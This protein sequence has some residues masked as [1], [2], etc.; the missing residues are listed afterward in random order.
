MKIPDEFQNLKPYDMNLYLYSFV[1]GKQQN[2][3]DVHYYYDENLL[4]FYVRVLFHVETQGAPGIVHG[5]AIASVMD[6]AM[7][8]V[9]FLNHLPAVTGSLTLNY[10]R[11]LPVETTMYITTSIEKTEGKR[12]YIVGK[13]FDGDGVLFADSKGIF[14]KVP[15]ERIGLQINK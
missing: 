15:S 8:G 9:A 13:M 2:Y 10:H 3:I 1:S 5:G 7:G 11:P 6:E 12:V 14:V 4:K